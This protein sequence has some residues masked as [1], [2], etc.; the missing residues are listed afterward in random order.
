MAN[1]FGLTLSP[2]FTGGTDYA[3]GGAMT[4]EYTVSLPSPF[5]SIQV[6][7]SNFNAI[8]GWNSSAFTLPPAFVP[9]S[10]LAN[11]SD[12]GI[13]SQIAQFCGNTAP[14]TPP[15]FNP[16]STLFVLWAGVNDFFLAQALM[17]TNPADSI[18][19][20]AGEITFLASIGAD[21]FLVPNLPDLSLTPEFLAAVAGLP[22]NVQA[23]L[24]IQLQ[25]AV[26]TYNGGLDFTLGQLE[27]GLGVD[28]VD[29]DLYTF[30]NES[31]SQFDNITQP[32]LSRDSNNNVVICDNPDGYLFWDNV[33]PTTA[34]NKLLG[35]AF[36]A[37]V[38][39]PASLALLSLALAVLGMRRPKW[40]QKQIHTCIVGARRRDRTGMAGLGPRDLKSSPISNAPLLAIDY[41]TLVSNLAVVVYCV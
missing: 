17:Q 13:P 1:A 20:L 38:P 33:H 18:A 30:I 23:A 35:E 19:N 6:T 12:T 29:F 41:D 22:S 28:I 36:A 10:P 7:D 24:K 21:H 31:L 2:S 25:N 26:M 32:C 14:C 34:A 16:A 9:G 27:N 39:E 40:S 11:V 8:T 15:A 3:V 4:G 37:A 5:G